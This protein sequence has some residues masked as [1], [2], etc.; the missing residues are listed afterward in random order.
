MG[1]FMEE[2][3]IKT[4]NIGKILLD[5]LNATTSE[6]ELA[7]FMKRFNIDV[8]TIETMPAFEEHIKQIRDVD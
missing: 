5:D 7:F 1:K 8:D 3:T 4:D 6:E 2:K